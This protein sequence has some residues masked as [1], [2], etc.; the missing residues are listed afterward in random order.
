MHYSFFP[1]SL[2]LILPQRVLSIDKSDFCGT[3]FTFWRMFV[4]HELVVK[5]HETMHKCVGG[6]EDGDFMAYFYVADL[7]QGFWD[8]MFFYLFLFLFYF[9]F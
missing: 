3:F 2:S 8:P 6:V 4:K 5:D 9:V 7:M 1:L